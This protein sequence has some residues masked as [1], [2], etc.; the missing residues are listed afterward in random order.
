MGACCGARASSKM[1]HRPEN[2][3]AGLGCGAFGRA[4]EHERTLLR[5]R[6]LNGALIAG[7]TAKEAAPMIPKPQ[8]PPIS[9][10]EVQPASLTLEDGR[11]A[12]KVLVWGITEDG[13]RIDLTSEAEFASGSEVVSVDG[14]KFITPKS[15]GQG[16]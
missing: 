5:S 6:I 8:L 1:E 11:D 13:R 4:Y 3:R 9:K 2:V 16:R 7:L 12:R 14:Q 15:K 10:I